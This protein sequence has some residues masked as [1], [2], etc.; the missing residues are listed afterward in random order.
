M[1]RW[2]FA[3][4]TEVG[5][6]ISP[7]CKNVAAFYKKFSRTRFEFILYME[8]VRFNSLD[9]IHKFIQMSW[10]RNIVSLQILIFNGLSKKESRLQVYIVP[11]YLSIVEHTIFNYPLLLL[12]S[13][14]LKT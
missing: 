5:Q 9:K 14:L 13:K 2:N 3:V 11:F 8:T 7:R 10:D 1:E 12:A 6:L 4:P